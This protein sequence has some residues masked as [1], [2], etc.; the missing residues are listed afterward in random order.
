[1]G[2]YINLSQI[3]IY[4]YAEKLKNG[5]LPPGRKILLTNIEQQFELIKNQGIQTVEELRLVLKNKKKVLEFSELS[6]LSVEYLT[7]LIREINSSLPKPNKLKDFP[8]ISAHVVKKLESI[9]IKNT[10]HLFDRIKSKQERVK[11]AEETGIKGEDILT[12]A[13]LTDLSRVRWVN[14]T[15]AFMLF[16]SGYQT[17][18]LLSEADPQKLHIAI[19]DINSK[20]IFYRGDIGLNDINICIQAAKEIPRDIEY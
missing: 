3:S 9:G 10:L 18:K 1:M 8:D 6:G 15:F 16:E 2:Y 5:Y 19:A 11:L 17:V 20:W 14:H 13:K 7:I 4:Q 12:L